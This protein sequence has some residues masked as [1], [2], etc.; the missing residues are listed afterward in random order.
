MSESTVKREKLVNPLGLVLIGL[1]FAVAMWLLLQ[2][3]QSNRF[4]QT[5]VDQQAEKP[6]FD[7][8]DY[9]Y[10]KARISSGELSID[11]QDGEFS[12]SIDAMLEAGHTDRLDILRKDFPG[13]K[14]N[15]KQLYRFELEQAVAAFYKAGSKPADNLETIAL[16]NSLAKVAQEPDMHTSKLVRRALALSKGLIQH[17]LVK[18]WYQIAF[19]ENKILFEEREKAE[20]MRD[21]GEYF[22]AHQRYT[23]AI[24]CLQN[25]IAITDDRDQQLSLRLLLMSAVNSVGN[26]LKLESLIKQITSHQPKSVLQLQQTAKVFLAAGR[27]DMA[28]PL[29]AELATND[30]GNRYKWLKQAA[31]W[32]EASAEPAIAAGFLQQILDQNLSKNQAEDE[33]QVR[34]LWI[35]SGE[36]EKALE[37]VYTRLDL[38]PRD[39]SALRQ[40]VALAQGLNLLAQ[41]KLW[42]EQLLEQDPDD[43]DG[44]INQ[45]SLSLAA[46]DLEEASRWANIAVVIEPDNIDSRRTLAQVS[47]WAGRPVEA[48]QHWTWVARKSADKE[49]YQQIIRLAEMNFRS[50]A[51]ADAASM[52][53][54]LEKPSEESIEKLIELHELDGRSG[55]AAKAIRNVIKTKGSSA[56]LLSR[57]GRL[58]QY[59]S[60]FTES[61]SVWNEFEEKYAPTTESRLARSELN[62]RLNKPEEASRVARELN[63]SDNFGDATDYHIRMLAELAWR[64]DEPE[65]GAL[66]EPSLRELEDPGIKR[67]LRERRIRAAMEAKQYEQAF[68]IAERLWR[69]TG[70]ISKGLIA[71]EAAGLMEDRSA[72]DTFLV[73]S[74]EN[75]RLHGEA[76]YW[77]FAA[78]RLTQL[79]KSSEATNAYRKAMQIEPQNTDVI[80]GMLWQQIGNASDEKLLASLEKYADLAG[81]QPSLWSAYAVGYLRVGDATT[82]LQWFS[83]QIEGME[84]DYGMMLTFADALEA[85]GQID[86]A[87]RVRRFTLTQLR[88]LLA[89]AVR[90]GNADILRQYA[91]QITRYGGVAGGE[92]WT[93]YLLAS[94]LNAN[95]AE[96]FWREDVGISWLMS[97]QRHEQARVIMARLHEER[98]RQPAWQQL[99]MAL[100]DNNHS[101]IKAV[102]ASGESISAGNRILALSALGKDRRAMK[103]ATRTLRSRVGL[104]ERRLAEQQY[105]YLRGSLPSYTNANTNTSRT[106]TLDVQRAGLALRHSFL[107]R[108]LGVNVEVR[109]S[110]LSS[111]EFDI[112]DSDQRDELILTL[113]F[114]G[115]SR[116]GSLTAGIVNADDTDV[117]YTQGRYYRR[118]K[119]GDSQIAIEF[120]VN[121]SAVQSPALQVAALQNRASVEYETSF[122]SRE[123]LR[124]RA[125]AQ[126]LFTRV[127]EAKIARGIEARGE[128][129]TRGNIGSNNWS[130]SVSLASSR[131][132][133]EDTLPAELQLNPTSNFDSILADNFTS[134][135]FGASLSR[136]GIGSDFPQ[137]SSPRY[138][139]NGTVAHAWPERS[140]GVLFEG[141]VGMRVVGS[142]ELSLSFS[143]DSL[144]SELG[145]GD[146]NSTG[147]GVNYRYHFKR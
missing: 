48:E 93:N 32:A 135:A 28:Y 74:V 40:G 43:I 145:R 42:N 47:E 97:T 82:S 76:R 17:D 105:V 86:T 44:I 94:D 56:F 68:T 23:T 146:A 100:H 61:L 115:R 142:D 13:I 11:E 95:P 24:D 52:L 132:S 90:D 27:A 147:F 113:G 70:E 139:L 53:S 133:R 140:F 114:G 58:Y 110:E 131:Y 77:V 103:V 5:E 26:P 111:D 55:D 6:V 128:L 54:K 137:V 8:L 37:Q 46:G 35:A 36:N 126:E 125:D 31:K 91:A 124:L 14:L 73:D 80:G 79:G 12:S 49:S 9:A 60:K 64:Y 118:N 2:N 106:N 116:G 66:I 30:G 4:D 129:G 63:S 57:L 3:T 65:L 1:A 134:L 39:L 69:E 84:S 121:E 81:A 67:F 89:A 130:S 123:Y 108:N 136:G 96:K 10:L 50:A 72:I 75:S 102:L 16:R 99:A 41:A 144:A 104:S 78:N 141:G 127:D 85:A 143:H 119:S 34:D 7:D 45:T 120:G 87:F 88:P 138:F 20:L 101:Q 21:C 112:A 71:M 25:A 51:A 15:R 92:E 18:S 59:H 62:W 98:V 29:Y 109:R 33:R 22:A 122:G 19:S 38:N 107:N 83:R 117:S